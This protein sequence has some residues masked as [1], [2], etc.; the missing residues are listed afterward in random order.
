MWYFARKSLT[1]LIHKWGKTP[2]E[3]SRTDTEMINF[4]L[5]RAP[6]EW[7]PLWG[8]L[9]LG[10][11]G[12]ALGLALA[13]LPLLWA[14]I[15]LLVAILAVLTIIDPLVGLSTALILG[16]TKPLTDYFV[17]QLPLDLGQIALIITLGVWAMKMA[18]ERDIRLPRSAINV[19]LLIFIGAAALSFLNALSLGYALKELIKWVQLLLAMWMVIDL[20]GEKR[21][22]AAVGVMLGVGA[23]EA[24]IG[25]WQFALRGDGPEHFLILGDRF[26]RAYG[27]FEQPNPYAGFIGLMA[28]L[29]VGL[30]LGA[31]GTWIKPVWAELK[32]SRPVN[33]RRVI[34]AAFN[35]KGLALAGLIGLCGL[36]AASLVM[37][38][39]RGAWLGFAAALVVILFAWPKKAW[40]GAALVIAG[41]VGGTLA[42]QFNL[43]PAAIASRLTDFTEFLQ[44]FDVRGVDISPANYAVLERLAHWQ[45]AQ[46]MARYNLWL[47]VGIGNYEPVYPGYALINWPYALGHAHNIYLNLLAETGLVGLIAYAGLWIN[48]FWQTWRITRHADGWQRAVALGLLGMWTHLSV[49]QLVD[50]LYVA[51]IHLHIGA[52]LG[53]LSILVIQSTQIRE[54]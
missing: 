13:R 18:R 22:P 33:M 17:P 37:S 5:R 14:A 12:I 52:A 30:A 46:E 20:A 32:A 38:W 23:V 2:G 45:T 49:H 19:P 24:L 25:V 11:G 29:A 31:L 39:S 47:G 28:P 36:L 8:K 4:S 53:V 40:V 3:L 44:T 35:S 50:K 34:P 41:V 15:G 26:Y 7:L 48:V 42:L 1:L 51:N 21:W 9:L 54:K 6:S 27:T 16:P 10:A 43:L